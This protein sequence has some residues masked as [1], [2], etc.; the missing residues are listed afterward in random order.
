MRLIDLKEK[1]MLAEWAERHVQ[2]DFKRSEEEKSYFKDRC[3]EDTY[4]ME[5]DFFT[6]ADLELLMERV[7][8]GGIPAD[9]RHILAVA[10]FKAKP[11]KPDGRKTRSGERES[12]PE[13]IYVF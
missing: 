8:K 12:I 9:V 13:F 6:I 11:E 3:D 1:Q 5:Y 2:D 4:M 7:S 10:A